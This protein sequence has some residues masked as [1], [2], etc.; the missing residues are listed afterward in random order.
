[1][2]AMVGRMAER[3]SVTVPLARMYR[4]ADFRMMVDDFGVQWM[5]VEAGEGMRR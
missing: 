4:G 5:F 1:M 2:R 3:A